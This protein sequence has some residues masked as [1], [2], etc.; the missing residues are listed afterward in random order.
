MNLSQLTTAQLETLRDNL[1]ATINRSTNAQSYIAGG[2]RQL[3][4]MDP[5]KAFEMLSKVNWELESRTDTGGDIFIHADF[6][7][8][9]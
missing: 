5:E 8:P 4:R 1:L 7:E 3:S 6:G 2:G 9:L